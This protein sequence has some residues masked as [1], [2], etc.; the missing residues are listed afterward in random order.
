MAEVD[1]RPDVDPVIYIAMENWSDDGRAS[2]KAYSVRT[3][4]AR[5]GRSQPV[6]VLA[7]SI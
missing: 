2:R 7:I 1:K 5:V 6:N 3:V 4:K